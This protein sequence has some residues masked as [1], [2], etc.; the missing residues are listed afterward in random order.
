MKEL[1][2]L[3]CI[4]PT[5]CLFG[6]TKWTGQTTLTTGAEVGHFSQ[7]EHTY[8]RT[9]S[10]PFYIL[11]GPPGYFSVAYYQYDTVAHSYGVASFGLYRTFSNGK[12]KRHTLRGSLRL[13]AQSGNSTELVV[14]ANCAW[15]YRGQAVGVGI[16]IQ[17]EMPSFDLRVHR[18]VTTLNGVKETERN[19]PG[20]LIAP[21][22]QIGPMDV[23]F[24]DFSA[25]RNAPFHY[26]YSLGFGSGLGD[27]DRYK[28]GVGMEWVPGG[29]GYHAD[30]RMPLSSRLSLEGFVTIGSSRQLSGEGGTVIDRDGDGWSIHSS[31]VQPKSVK[32]HLWHAGATLH[33]RLQPTY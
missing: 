12:H 22:I 25:N 29:T 2:T 23:F 33:I 11:W 21:E 20:L 24:F 8:L 7:T 27:I 5:A 1:L 6:Q 30:I 18:V 16:G 3:V 9:G 4:I 10:E 28:L 13:G 14:L 32:T 31:D 17:W 19:N 15:H 26:L